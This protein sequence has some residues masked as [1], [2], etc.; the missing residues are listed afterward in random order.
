MP[1]LHFRNFSKGRKGRSCLSRLFQIRWQ[2][3]T[4]PWP[5]FNLTNT[6]VKGFHIKWYFA[7]SLL[8][9]IVV[10]PLRQILIQNYSTPHPNK[11]VFS[12]HSFLCS[13]SW[14]HDNDLTISL[15]ST[16]FDWKR[17]INVGNELLHNRSMKENLSRV[18]PLIN[19]IIF[20]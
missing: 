16:S 2:S 3:F 20:R 11:G 5:A 19:S 12:R 13:S 10:L 14:I 8:L 9:C 15:I 18:T 7:P 1:R 17:I 4:N 6:K